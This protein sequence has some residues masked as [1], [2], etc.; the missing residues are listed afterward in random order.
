MRIPL[1]LGTN[2]ETA[3]LPPVVLV[4]DDDPSVRGVVA[5]IV[6]EGGYHVLTA[7]GG[8]QALQIT[9]EA[10][11]DL[12]LTDFM[13]PGM[14]GSELIRRVKSQGTISRFLVMSG[15]KDVAL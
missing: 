15:R 2:R 6:A 10:H 8:P 11:V 3:A 9:T 1:W 7:A 12:L 4:V 5:A 13:M 14:S